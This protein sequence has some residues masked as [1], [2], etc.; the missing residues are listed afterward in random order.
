MKIIAAFIRWW[1][2]EADAFK[3]PS[4]APNGVPRDHFAKVRQHFDADGNY[5]FKDAGLAR[6][7]KTAKA[8]GATMT[9]GTWVETTLPSSAAWLPTAISGLNAITCV[10][11][12]DV[13]TTAAA[14]STD[15]GQTWTASTLPSAPW[16]SMAISGSYAVALTDYSTVCAYS[17]NGGQ[18]W[19]ASTLPSISSASWVVSISGLNAVAVNANANTSTGIYSTNGGQT[20]TTM[21]LPGTV[22][23]HAVSVSGS[24]AIAVGT[25]GPT[26]YTAYST[27]G[28][29]TWTAVTNPIGAQTCAIDGSNA[30]SCDG[31][32][33]TYS[34]NGGQTWTPGT[35][36]PSESTGFGSASISGSVA[37]LSNQSTLVAYSSNA[38]QTWQVQT[39]PLGVPLY[40]AVVGTASV[41]AVVNGTST[42]A[43]M[44]LPFA[45]APSAPTLTAPANTATIN[46]LT[47]TT[48][49]AT[50]NST[51]SQN[52]NAFAMRVAANGGAYTYWDVAT[53]TF[54]SSIV[55]NPSN[56]APGNSFSVVLPA[57]ALT[58]GNSYTWSMASQESGANLQG[59]FAGD[60]A[61]R[62]INPNFFAFM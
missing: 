33:T 60:F 54:S 53:Q 3:A 51:D 25:N 61:L 39:V 12:Y 26:W 32:N 40:N 37:V 13:A 24:T 14:Y 56:V 21:T 44:P 23:W 2:G 10:S 46:A 19:T 30:V 41:F 50:Y 15:G 9:A 7:A 20:W 31:V 27:N 17:T 18:T 57:N 43:Y 16:S 22:Y 49:S 28:G 59:P 35:V 11:N 45:S 55:W 52:Q 8:V 38:G 5:I 36:L 42:A 47:S 4:T 58:S 1:N 6:A 34:T 48:F 62:S 29:Q